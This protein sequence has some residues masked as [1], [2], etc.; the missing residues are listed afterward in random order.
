M[1]SP[2]MRTPG[3][4]DNRANANTRRTSGA[5]LPPSVEDSI[6][7]WNRQRIAQIAEAVRRWGGFVRPAPHANS[8]HRVLVGRA[9]WPSREFDCATRFEQW[10]R[11]AGAIR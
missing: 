5:T 7:V 1:S 6:E 2:E 8:P 11:C 10:A 3:S 9:G 4:G